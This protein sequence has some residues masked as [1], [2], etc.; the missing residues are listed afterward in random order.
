MK[1]IKGALIMSNSF[2]QLLIMIY[3]VLDGLYQKLEG[4]KG[5]EKA[6]KLADETYNLLVEKK[7]KA[8]GY[9]EESIRQIESALI[10]YYQLLEASRGQATT[11]RERARKQEQRQRVEISG[12]L[13]RA[14]I[15]L[16]TI[17]SDA[18]VVDMIN[19]QL[20]RGLSGVDVVIPENYDD[21]EAVNLD[22][23]LIKLYMLKVL[24]VEDT[25]KMGI[26]EVLEKDIRELLKEYKFHCSY[27][28]KSNER[29][30]KI[31]REM[32]RKINL[33]K[34]K[35]IRT[36]EGYLVGIENHKF[37]HEE[38]N[39]IARFYNRIEF[40]DYF[41][42]IEKCESLNEDYMYYTMSSILCYDYDD[43]Y[44]ISYYN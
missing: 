21:I 15:L 42:I 33:L 35:F 10:S 27:Y 16:S 11:D 4:L 2:I 7:P 26:L 8:S 6:E 43:L 25:Y 24:L 31:K 30:D 17:R 28:N 32:E 34:N 12:Y 22:L 36:V 23:T 1:E 37:T 5:K 39:K 20:S 38:L 14:Y 3:P 29:E 19:F 41:A 18:E 9:V 44:E 13:L 40:N